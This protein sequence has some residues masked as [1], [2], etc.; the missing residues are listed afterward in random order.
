MLRNPGQKNPITFEVV[1]KD[2]NSFRIASTY[3]WGSSEFLLEPEGDVYR[4][5]GLGAN[6]QTMPLSDRP[7]FVDFSK[8]ARS[9]WS[10]SIGTLEI[11]STSTTVKTQQNSYS[12]GILLR[13]RPP[14]GQQVYVFARGVGFVQ[15]AEGRNAFVLD[16][17]ASRL[18]ASASIAPPSAP[19]SP[20]SSGRASTQSKPVS[21]RNS[22]PV[23]VGL[24]FN[25]FANEPKT[26]QNILK[27]FDQTL[28][29]GVNLLVGG[30]S[31]R[32]LE[33][34][35]GR[36]NLGDITYLASVAESRKMRVVYTLK[37][38]ET[39]HKAVPSD[40]DNKAWNS[41]EMRTRVLN[42]IDEIAPVLRKGQLKWFNFGYEIDGY[43]SKHTRE[44]QQF[45]ELHQ[46]ASARLRELIPGVEIGS[47]IAFMDLD[48]LSGRL[49]PLDR[50]LD[51]L[52]V[53][54]SPI[55]PGWTVRDPSSLPQDV[56]KMK[57]I[58]AGRQVLLQEIAYPTSSLNRGSEDKQAEFISMAFDEIERD[59][60]SYCAAN[61]M[62]LAD[63]SDADTENFGKFYGLPGDA[64]FKAMMQTLGMFDTSG[65]AKKSW[66]VF[67]RRAKR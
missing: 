13:H 36:Y 61:F 30:A 28:D 12:D 59:P 48:A 64:K 8:P 4:M 26:P 22:G 3:P 7:V 11:E 40:L 34:Q 58:A 21:Q 51:Y 10:N 39:I 65:R 53:T 44:I 57:R 50:E 41:P 24:T 33:P 15:F 38:I 23:P 56:A 43:L 6:G 16:E 2:G 19:A 52:A 54:Y 55:E 45:V 32:E 67:T 31:W 20:R 17:S 9:K 47:T 66:S 25:S 49:A 63:L 5:T 46:V 62:M 29:A 27:R 14:G 42:L 1:E 18:N 37:L 60:N 35:K